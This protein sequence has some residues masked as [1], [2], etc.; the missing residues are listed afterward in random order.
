MKF[1]FTILMLRNYFY[2]NKMLRSEVQEL[3]EAT[4]K[5]ESFIRSG[6]LEKQSAASQ[7]EEERMSRSIES[8]NTLLSIVGEHLAILTNFLL[9]VLKLFNYEH[10]QMR[11]NRHYLKSPSFCTCPHSKHTYT[12]KID[13]Q[14]ED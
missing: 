8:G 3:V 6:D 2:A 1:T 9:D 10:S 13:T 7:S 12:T 5:L 11:P 4:K 14:L